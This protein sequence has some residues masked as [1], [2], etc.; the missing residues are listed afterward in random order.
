SKMKSTGTQYWASPNTGATNSSGWSGLPGGFR[1]LSG[2]FNRVGSNGYWWGS[3]E[4]NTYNAWYRTL[5]D[6]NGAV[7]KV[8]NAK[9]NGFS[10]R[11]VRD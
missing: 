10:V 8:S 1:N 9:A 7:F 5:V 4:S 3:T 11:C 2:T 6:Y